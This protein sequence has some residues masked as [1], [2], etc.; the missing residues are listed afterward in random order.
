MTQL[1]LDCE[2]YPN[3]FLAMFMNESG[4]TRSFES[5]GD[6]EMPVD[7]LMQ[8]LYTPGVEHVTFNGMHYDIPILQYLQVGATK[9]QLK[10]ASDDIIENGLQSWQFY[11]NYGITEPTI[12]HIDLKELAI[13]QVG[14]KLYGGRLH[15]KLLRELP[16]DPD[17]PLTREQAK[18]VKQYCRNDLL[19]TRDLRNELSKQI[20]LRRAM[21]KE[22]GV[23]L[24]SKSDAQIAEAVLKSEFT[25][26]AGYPP[27]RVP[28]NKK[29]FFYE[30]PKYIKFS[31]P[32]LKEALRI[33]KDAE[34]VVK[35]TGHVEMPEAIEKLDI[36]I[37]GKKYKVGIGGLHSQESEVTHYASNSEKLFDIDVASY[38]P[39]L[40]LNMGM[41]PLALQGY[42]TEAYRGILTRRLEA[43]RV[44]DKVTDAALKI[45][46]NGTFGKTS[47][48]YSILYNP[49][50]MIR[51]TLSGQLSLLMLIEKA[52]AL[53]IPI[54]SA[55]TDGIVAKCPI[56][57]VEMLQALVAAWERV[58]NLNTE[59]N[60][61]RALHS[62]D[63]NNYV[64]IKTD[65]SA[66]VKGTYRTGD[67]GKNPTNEICS[68][69]VVKYLQDGTLCEQTI[70]EC[71]DIR[72]F[73]TL[74]TVNGG[75]MK[76][77]EYL[78][79]AIRWYYANNCSGTIKYKTNSNDVPRSEG[80]KPV[81]N[82]P[83]EFPD[84]INYAWYIAECRE[85]L[86]DLGATPRPVQEKLPRKNS[87]AWKE[88]VEQ[89]KVRIG[90]KGEWEWAN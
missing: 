73:I 86:M 89:G 44:G 56:D 58:C 88:L 28:Y 10:Q 19:L 69:A 1:L 74:R 27:T 55:N 85:I 54:V 22:Y 7:A 71:R 41:E 77:E 13:G 39:N 31:D 16:Y 34:L 59:W 87:K 40:M 9:T 78:G 62:R 2:V 32:A 21:S 26:L 67:I 82:L 72:K 35:D 12:N 43:K 49:E 76:E 79:K 75:A 90:H 15:S 29:S 4:A 20:E 33:I 3:Y 61:Y 65:G 46:L 57:K 51:T 24:R 36:G 38:Y 66:K 37:A 45:T 8:L 84:D 23:D 60:E 11:K 53:G 25:R 52:E 14:L 64:A 70:H 5:F 81:M 17:Q 80:G 6:D 47:N 42:F 30:P 48:K 50:F 63:V 68:L 83:D 18:Q